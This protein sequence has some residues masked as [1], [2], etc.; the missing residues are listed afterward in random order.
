[1]KLP[2]RPFLLPPPLD[3]ASS[4]EISFSKTSSTFS[5]SWRE[6]HDATSSALVS[7]GSTSS[8]PKPV[9]T[10]SR[11]TVVSKVIVN[12]ASR[13]LRPLH[14]RLPHQLRS[15]SFGPLLLR[16][17]QTSK[18]LGHLS[19][20]PL[21]RHSRPFDRLYS[22]ISSSALINWRPELETRVLNL[23]VWRWE[24]GWI[25]QP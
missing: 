6:D 25:P 4:T 24:N 19:H 10:A 12:L 18:S 15:P 7:T 5:W 16:E 9:V 1:M 2:H 3:Y 14:L 8:P 13:N 22:C 23:N 20:P 11:L 21:F 17:K